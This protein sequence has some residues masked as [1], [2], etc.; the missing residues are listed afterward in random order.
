MCACSTRNLRIGKNALWV[1]KQHGHSIAT[2]LRA[3]AA[4]AEGS[5]E[6]D[7]ETIKSSMNLTPAPRKLP[8]RPN[9]ECHYC[10]QQGMLLAIDSLA[11][12]LSVAEVIHRLCAP[13]SAVV[14]GG[15]WNP[16][17]LLSKEQLLMPKFGWGGR[18]RTSEC[19]DQNPLPY[20]LATSQAHKK[21]TCI[22]RRR[23]RK[24]RCAS[25]IENPR[26]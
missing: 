12:D 5:V 6:T 10:R 19:R 8:V 18:M 21:S 4:W 23:S 14:S 9:E 3:Y 20:H 26:Y 15:W 16:K 24:K 2:I 1:A 11:V 25:V 17:S 13:A 22:L 7:I